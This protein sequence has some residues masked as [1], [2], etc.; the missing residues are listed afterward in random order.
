MPLFLVVVFFCYILEV[1]PS[2]PISQ[3]LGSKIASSLQELSH[4]E[5]Q[6]RIAS[7]FISQYGSSSLLSSLSLDTMNNNT[8]TVLAGPTL[9]DGTGDPPK[10]NAVIII[11][12]N[13]IF[14][15]T[16]EIEYY[17]QYYSLIN[18]ESARVN[19]LDLTGKYVIPGLFDMHAHVGGVRKNSYNQNFSENALEMLL[20]Y[21][22]TTIRNPAGPTNQSIAL[23]HNVSEG[24]ID[25]PEIFTAG[26]LLNGPQIPIPFV[27]K[28][29]STEEQ[30]R[31][32]VH[33]QA[34]AGVDFI[35]LY[36]GLSPHLVKAAI[37]EAHSLGIRVIGHL[38]MTSWTDAANLGIDALTHGVPVNPFLLSAGDKREKFLENGGGPFDHFL[39]LDLVD[40]NSTEVEEMINALVENDIPVDPTLSIYEALLKE[41]ND[42]NDYGFSDPQ[43][44]LRWAKVLQLTKIMYDNGVQILS[45]SD[46]PNFE[47][48]PGASL[49]NELEL[50]AEAGIRPLEVIEIATNNGAKA[51]GIDDI[52]GTIQS[53]KQADMI[54]LSANPIQ[55]ISNTQEIEAVIVDG[56]FA[57]I[58]NQGLVNNPSNHPL[59]YICDVQ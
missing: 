26:V 31:E 45:G 13:K 8:I 51:L 20:D 37:D 14:G 9:I 48:V 46:I 41:E 44:Q 55:N 33:H 5:S 35:K 38:Y 17:D 10:P 34:E 47:L 29:I 53:G 40:F 6:G 12:G 56:R 18:N 30:A 3:Y 11:N 50:L 2:I 28:Q 43:N 15:V 32:E 22:I 54:V 59:S 36:V 16:N 27:E 21:G 52:T 23:K 39:W 58:D 19:I 1:L 7:H 42:G 25:G 24:Q 57:D 4:Y 49:H